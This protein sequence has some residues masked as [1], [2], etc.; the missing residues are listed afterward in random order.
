MRK[1]FGLVLSI[2]LLPR[3][4]A[5]QSLEF[6]APASVYDPTT[7]ALM[8]DLAARIIPGYRN[9][10]R[11][12]YLANMSVLQLVAGNFEPAYSARL[13]LQRL[14]GGTQRRPPAD[15]ALVYDLYAHTKALQAQ[16]RLPFAQ[17]FDLAFWETIP[18]FN[19]L[20]AYHVE[21]WLEAPAAVYAAALQASFD[22]LR[23]RTRIS[24][25]EALG[26]IWQYLA[27]DAYRSLGPIAPGSSH[28]TRI[29]ATSSR[30]MS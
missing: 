23:S 12:Q 24:A 1:A 30:T 15:P 27:F 28:S 18:I 26:L 25:S 13:D 5:A 16:Y 20:D 11:E 10:N 4:A 8:R 14:R 17:A 21:S 2:M 29:G 7:P 22:R 3:L 19:N 6:R 9:D